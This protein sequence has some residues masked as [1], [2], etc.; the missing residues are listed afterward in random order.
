MFPDLQDDSYGTLGLEGPASLSGIPGADDPIL[1]EDQGLSFGVYE[2]FT[3]GGTDL[4]V[5]TLTGEAWYLLNTYGNAY[6]T[7]GRWL[8][9]QI[10]TTGSIS[11]QINVQIFPLGVGANQVQR[12]FVFDGCGTFY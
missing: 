11:G 10:T 4:N 7:D 8:V 9:A 6:P 3:S 2:Y 1:S 12:T 5:N